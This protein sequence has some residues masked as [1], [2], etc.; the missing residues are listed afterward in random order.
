M[1]LPLLNDVLISVFD[2][3]TSTAVPGSLVHPGTGAT[4]WAT[5]G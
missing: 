4:Y 1:V 2:I 3:C 5:I